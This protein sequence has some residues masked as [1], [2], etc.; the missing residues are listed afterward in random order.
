MSCFNVCSVSPQ[1]HSKGP[2]KGFRRRKPGPQWS[3]A[4]GVFVC[5]TAWGQRKA[6]SIYTCGLS[7]AC[8]TWRSSFPGQESRAEELHHQV[9]QRVLHPVTV[10]QLC[11]HW[12]E[13][14]HI[15][16]LFHIYTVCSRS[17]PYTLSLYSLDRKVFKSHISSA[18]LTHLICFRI[19]SR[20]RASQ[21][22]PSWSQR[23]MWTSSPT[24]AGF[25]LSIVE[26]V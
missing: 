15:F 6:T 2:H 21:T 16:S 19:Q 5:V 24:S 4:W 23:K 25:L 1:A 17:N 12:G 13:G 7:S 22:S 26:N 14:L 11:G 8:L 20:Q 10:D 9:E 18:N 3:W